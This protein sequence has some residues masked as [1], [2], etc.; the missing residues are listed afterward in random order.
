MQEMAVKTL[1]T[2]FGCIA[3]VV[4]CKQDGVWDG[5]GQGRRD[6]S[7]LGYLPPLCYIPLE[8]VDSNPFPNHTAGVQTR[9]KNTIF[10]SK[11]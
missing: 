1:G 2:G 10:S 3:L 7:L 9:T 8:R 4:H 5:E 11:I 6:V